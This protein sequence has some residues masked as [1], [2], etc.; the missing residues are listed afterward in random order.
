MSASITLHID[1][2]VLGE[3]GEW[4]GDRME[5]KEKSKAW[6]LGNEEKDGKPIDCN[7]KNMAVRIIRGGILGEI[8]ICADGEHKYSIRNRKNKTK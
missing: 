4:D 8:F 3:N 7:W 2:L 1:I 6:G 5:I